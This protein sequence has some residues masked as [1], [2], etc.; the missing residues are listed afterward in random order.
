MA[1]ETLKLLAAHAPRGE[2]GVRLVGEQ[3]YVT[4]TLRQPSGALGSPLYLEARADKYSVSVS[5]QAD[6][7]R[8]PAFCIDR[9]I[10]SDG[11]F[12]LAYRED[13]NIDVSSP[14][15][16]RAWWAALIK[17]LMLQE[18]VELRGAWPEEQQM[19]HGSN[20][21]DLQLRSEAAATPFGPTLENAIRA[22]TYEVG[23]I[24][25][26]QQTHLTLFLD[27]RIALRCIQ[28]GRLLGNERDCLCGSGKSLL[29]CGSHA[30]AAKLLLTL[31]GERAQYKRA[32]YASMARSG[33]TCCGRL[34][35]CG[36]RSAIQRT[37]TRRL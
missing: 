20:G 17:F 16:A 19:D 37:G 9:H 36:L 10:M 2:S 7:R 5:E 15:T 11:S 14:E 22:G 3:M 8:Y 25:R 28:G 6:R 27:N 4:L 1:N 33:A 32:F 26:G 23:V 31:L 18:E 13:V 21:A 12:C 29:A 35:T 30:A 34:A 24:A